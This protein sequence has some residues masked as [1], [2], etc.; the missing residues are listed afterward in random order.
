MNKINEMEKLEQYH[1]IGTVEEIKKVIS[2]LSDDND[3]SLIDDMNLLQ[4]YRA[5]G[6]PT[7]IYE[8]IGGLDVELGK[9]RAIGTVEGY[10]RAIQSSIENY[11]LYREYKAKVQE[12]EAIGTVEEIKEE[13]SVADIQVDKLNAYKQ[14]G[15]ID[16]FKA[17]KEKND[18]DFELLLK[19]IKESYPMFKGA[20][21]ELNVFMG[22]VMRRFTR[23]RRQS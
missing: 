9:Y 7:Q 3:N 21:V 14:V 16:E 2:F 13:L 8:K 15:T 20:Y 22:D 12:F 4:Q 5:I 6:T 10:E 18:K 17:L 1:A 19:A 11:N 23:D